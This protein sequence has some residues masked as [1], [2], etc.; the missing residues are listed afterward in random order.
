M[1][2]N[3]DQEY[4]GANAEGQ[5]QPASEQTP[6]G[7]LYEELAKRAAQMAPMDNTGVAGGKDRGGFA[8]EPSQS[9]TNTPPPTDYTKMGQFANRMGAWNGNEKFDRNWDDKS[10][11]Y[12]MLTVMSHFDPNAGVTPEL[13]AAL[14]GANIYGAKF[15]GSGD[16]LTVDNAGGYDRFGTGGT[17][18]VIA[19]FKDPNNTNKQWGAWQV[20]DNPQAAGGG[21]G[22]GGGY[23]GPSAMAMLLRRRYAGMPDQY[24]DLQFMNGSL[25]NPVQFGN[26]PNYTQ[27]PLYQ[28]M[29]KRLL[30]TP[31]Q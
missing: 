25:E 4:L 18:D 22:G 6:K 29:M 7:N 14:N 12:K 28:E 15:S 9:D 26:K 21:P 2:S 24:P 8:T 19:G 30:F 23:A 17:G 31:K 13:I 5:D 11:R 3:Y 16:K 20:D 10:E 1:A 27:N